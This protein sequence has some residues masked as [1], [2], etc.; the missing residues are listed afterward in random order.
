[1]ARVAGRVEQVARTRAA[2][3]RVGQ[4]RR[5]AVGGRRRR[6][7]PRRRRQPQAAASNGPRHLAH[8][9]RDAVQHPV[10]PRAVAQSAGYRSVRALARRRGSAGS[11][12]TRPG[13]GRRRR[14]P[15]CR[16]AGSPP[17]ASRALDAERHLADLGVEPELPS[18]KRTFCA[19]DERGLACRSA[20]RPGRYGNLR[21]CRW[22]RSCSPRVRRRPAPAAPPPARRAAAVAVG[23]VLLDD[24]AGRRDLRVHDGGHRP[25][26]G[27]L[28]AGR[29]DLVVAG[30][31]HRD[32]R[33]R[34]S[35]A[36]TTR[37]A[38]RWCWR[39][40]GATRSRSAI[41]SPTS[42]TARRAGA[43]GALRAVLLRRARG[44]RSR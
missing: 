30:A 44:S 20:P 28:A 42:R 11:R 17:G 22:R 37:S 38:A 36:T 27:R 9:R 1:M 33:R 19:F 31:R 34:G 6:A 12:A 41:R 2:W 35:P 29:G 10:D 3:A 24:R 8:R 13:G 15:G 18:R 7:D 32:P 23:R 16:R 39:P 5:P 21:S 14:A 25:D 40:A 26:A 43:A 4:R